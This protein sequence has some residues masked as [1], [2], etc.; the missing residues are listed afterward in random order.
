MEED[1]ATVQERSG[2]IQEKWDWSKEK[3]AIFRRY[4][5]HLRAS[6]QHYTNS[7]AGFFKG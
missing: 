2:S 7:F 3:I 4:G 5:G 1:E 6:R